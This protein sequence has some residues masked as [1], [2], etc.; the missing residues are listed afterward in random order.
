MDEGRNID[1]ARFNFNVDDIVKSAAILKREIDNIKREQTRLRKEGQTSSTAFVQNEAALKALNTE[2]RAHVKALADTSKQ[3]AD[4][5]AR[6][7]LLD[8]VLGQEVVTIKEA[9]DQNKL[10]NQLR[11]DTNVTTEEGRMQ[12]EQLNAQ[13]DRNNALVRENAD[14]Y[15]EQKLNIGN[16]SES[17]KEAL[18]DLNLFEGGLGNITQNFTVFISKSQ[19]AG[20]VTN[21]V[22]NSL[23]GAASGFLSLTKAALGFILTPVGAVLAIIA[24]AF[25]LV[26][27]AMNRSEEA[28]NKIRR[29]FAPFEGILNSVLKALEP[30]GEFLIDGIVVAMELAEQAVYRAIDAF[31]DIASFLG[32]ESLAESARE[33]N[34]EIQQGAADAQALAD[35]EARLTKQQR[36][37]RLVQLQYQKEAEQF[38]QIRDDENRSIRERIAANEQLGAVLEQQLQDELRIAQTALEVANLRIQAEGESA[39]ALDAQAEA[40]EQIADIE[41]RITGQ[42]SEQLTNRV[43]LEREAEEKRQEAIDKRIEKMNEEL[44]LFIAQQGVR[45]RTLQEELDLEREVSAQKEAILAEELRNKRLSQ[46]AY[47]TEVL[48]LRNELARREAEIAVDNAGREIEEYRRLLAQRREENVFLSEQVLADRIAENEA[49][50]EQELGFQQL[51]LEQGVIDQNEFDAAV[52]EAKENN[53]LANKEIED[54]RAAVE[55]EEAAE[56]RALEF[57]EE[58]ERLIEEGATKAEIL[59]AQQEEERAVDLERLQADRDAGLI[60]EEL[61]EARRAAIDRR[62]KQQELQREK[63]LAEQKLSIATGLLSAAAQVIDKD[64][65]AGKAIALAQAGINTFQGISAG[66]KLGYPAAIPAVALA[67]ATGF[68]AVRNIVKTKV[69]SA[70]GGGSAGGGGGAGITANST[71]NVGGVSLGSG[72]NLNSIAASGNAAVQDQLEQNASGRNIADEV[73]RAAEEGTRRGAEQGANEGLTNLSDNRRIQEESA[74]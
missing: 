64:S 72:V 13:L 6:E 50:L 40:L 27:N 37:A 52:A 24:G 55:K 28:T 44:A 62:S 21:L 2:Y 43:S 29:A 33:F 31:A 10:L 35:A 71:A 47:N 49:L 5:A 18:S 32:F 20:G 34:K 26:Q 69:P 12:L 38:R 7:Q 39:A 57:E 4:T 68:A 17:I 63:I 3:A 19:E 73:G 58:L 66:V 53:R 8:A 70:S 36:E 23:K 48:N 14:A 67:T 9:R 74:F 1:L 16:Y 30:V 46:E 41:E 60:S 65:A 59:R 54:E 56:L 42:R 45:A 51:R 15:L 25:L 61:F 11:N 22:G